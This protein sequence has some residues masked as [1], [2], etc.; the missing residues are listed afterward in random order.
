MIVV[1]VVAMA[2]NGVIGRNGQ[3]PWRMPTDLKQ[4]RKLTLGKP[5]IMG[6]KTYQSIGKPLDGRDNIVVTRQK[7]FAAPGVHV[8]D[9]VAG[10]VALGGELAARRG[11]DEVAVIGGGD[12]FRAALPLTRRVYLTLVRGRPDGDIVLDAFDPKVWREAAREPMQQSA[13]DQFP[14]EFI[15][16]DRQS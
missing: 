14:A 3:L 5:V 10:A 2:E 9:T 4:F 6:R 15:V 11:V 1:F 12:V 7:D 16:L 13:G 8:A